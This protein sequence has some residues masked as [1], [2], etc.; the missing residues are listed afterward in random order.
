VKKRSE[1][2]NLVAY[3]KLFI[4]GGFQLNPEDASYRDTVMDLGVVAER[5]LFDF[6]EAEKIPSKGSSSIVKRMRQLHRDRKL[7]ELIDAYKARLAIGLLL[8][9]S[10]RESHDMLPLS[11]P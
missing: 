3:M 10:P 5:G 9:P 4:T 2:R 11:E 6:L 1:A 7:D 8:D